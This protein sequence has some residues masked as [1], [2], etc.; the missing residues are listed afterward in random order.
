MDEPSQFDSSKISIGLRSRM[1]LA[2]CGTVFA[3]VYG[4]CCNAGTLKSD[5]LFQSFCDIS[6]FLGK[7]ILPRTGTRILVRDSILVLILGKR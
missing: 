7:N 2:I 4:F 3:I 5:L 1:Q 6:C